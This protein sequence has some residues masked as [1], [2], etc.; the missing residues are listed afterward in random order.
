MTAGKFYL[1]SG[2]VA[3]FADLGIETGSVLRTAGL[4]EDLLLQG[5]T[6]LT[7]AQFYRCWTAVEQ[8]SG[9]PALA[10]RLAA[11]LRV[12]TFQPLVFAALCSPDLRRAAERIA[13][14]KRLLGPQLV[15]L[16]G[17]AD[18]L[19]LTMRWPVR[20]PPPSG[21]IAYEL[22]FWVALA[23]LGTRKRIVPLRVTAPEPPHRDAVD[24]WQEY[25]G[26]PV[27]S[28]TTAAV[29]FAGTD[30]TTPFLT[31][32]AQMWQVFEPDLRRRLADLDQAEST[33]HRVR[34]VL[35]E[36]LPAGNHTAAGVAKRLALS[37]RTLQRRLAEEHTSFQAVLD[38][39]RHALARH[40]LEQ[41][42]ISVTEIALLL[43]YDESRSF[44]RAFRAWSGTTPHRVR[45]TEETLK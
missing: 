29:T 39:T 41:Q 5:Q 12:E 37:T 1:G 34:A 9:D 33:A 14:Y 40:Y 10:A 19:T 18:R 4:P 20:P 45:T 31:S 13:L 3:M 44:Y 15:T 36:L 7:P 23:R 21:L 6:A 24:A 2:T 25:L 32:N 26:V 27:E 16:D 17:G 11:Q 28:G 35:V 8:V 42:E 38:E 30:T 43:G 22:A